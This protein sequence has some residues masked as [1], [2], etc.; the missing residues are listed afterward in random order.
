VFD[1]VLQEP[2]T[3]ERVICGRE[4]KT[5]MVIVDF[6]S[7]KNVDTAREKGY[8]AGKNIGNEEPRSKLLGIKDFT[9]KSLSLWGNKSPTPPVTAAS[10][11]VLNQMLRK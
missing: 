4:E 11:G 1:V 8:D 10:C 9:L 3:S 2:G 7:V 5:S 6:K